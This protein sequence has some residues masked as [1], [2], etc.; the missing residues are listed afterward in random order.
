[1]LVGTYTTD[2]PI[3]GVL[4]AELQALSY[5]NEFTYVEVNYHKYESI[6]ALFNKIAMKLI[7]A[8]S[9][10]INKAN[11]PEKIKLDYTPIETTPKESR[12]ESLVTSDTLRTSTNENEKL[13]DKILANVKVES[14]K[15][16]EDDSVQKCVQCKSKFNLLTRKHH[17]RSCGKI[18]CADCTNNMLSLPQYGYIKPVRVCD[19]CVSKLSGHQSTKAN[20]KS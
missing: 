17:C 13:P 9:K 2:T 19:T 12:R 5:Q 16:M 15:W 10:E 1:M 14:P 6:E 4:E 7:D 18:Y 20:L 8:I 11:K 3:R